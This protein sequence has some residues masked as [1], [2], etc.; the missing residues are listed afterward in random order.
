MRNGK[1]Y[2]TFFRM[3][4]QRYTFRVAFQKVQRE[5]NKSNGL[6]LQILS[7]TFVCKVWLAVLSI[8]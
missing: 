2:F 3:Q 6:L 5:K 8:P 4:N 1:V 7:V